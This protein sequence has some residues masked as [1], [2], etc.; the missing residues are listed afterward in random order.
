[1][2]KRKLFFFGLFS[3]LIL[4]IALGSAAVSAH[5]TR[6]NLQQ[7]QIAQNLLTEHLQLSSTSYRLFKQ[8]TDEL[9]FGRN[10]NQAKVRNKQQLIDESLVRIKTLEVVQRQALGEEVTA[11]SIEDTDELRQLLVDII[12]EFNA[13]TADNL[14][15]PPGQQVRVQTLL[16]DTI[17][18]QFREAIN[19]AVARQSRVV[20]TINTKIEVLNTTIVWVTI[21]LGLLTG[22]FIIL[23]CFWL[24]NSLYQPLTVLKSGTD[25]IAAGNYNYR[26][27]QTL[28]SEFSDLVTALNSLVEKLSIHEAKAQANRKQL[29]Y[30][31]AQR[32]RELTEANRLL[33]NIDSRRRQFIADISHELRTPL[34][35]IRGEAQVTLRQK[36]LC[37]NDYRATL[38]AILEQSVSLSRLVD[39]MLLLIRAEMQQLQLEPEHTELSPLIEHQVQSWQ[40]IYAGRKISFSHKIVDEQPL[41][42]DKQ[43]IAQVIAIL[44]ENALK[45]SRPESPVH[46]T[47]NAVK[48]GYTFSVK[49]EG[50]GISPADQAQIFERFV[51]LRGTGSGLGLGLPIAKAIV[52]AHQGSIHVS[53]EQ[54]HGATFSVFLP[55][56]QQKA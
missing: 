2:Y 9:L 54:G 16:E 39:D 22:P 13:I 4:L 18:N 46:I 20:T 27:P 48:H 36:T 43:R 26:L 34:T 37:E 15:Q 42:I 17:D 56:E 38:S 35:I 29:K 33:T 40:K 23:G 19:A 12:A 1:M 51:R 25:A 21:G 11:G 30:E 45:Y 52:E 7:S 53:S 49:D 8:L 10:A 5:L 47:L 3:T 50:D 31:V 41:F 24:F 14:A 6:E 28:D 55:I 32:T 44:L